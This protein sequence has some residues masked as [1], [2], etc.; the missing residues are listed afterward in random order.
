MGL[1]FRLLLRIGVREGDDSRAVV[2]V[3]LAQ[4]RQAQ[5]LNHP[6]AR[7]RK[8][9]RGVGVSVVRRRA[10]R[11]LQCRTHSRSTM[12]DMAG[13]RRSVERRLIDSPGRPLVAETKL[14]WE[15]TTPSSS[16]VIGLRMAISISTRRTDHQTDALRATCDVRRA[17]DTRRG[18]KQRS[19]HNYHLTCLPFASIQMV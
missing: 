3:D 15:Q 19:A 9:K 14:R 11:G 17:S 6:S 10:L 4:V 8:R 13:W 18:W 16:A 5:L 7:V 12:S 1:A 2:V